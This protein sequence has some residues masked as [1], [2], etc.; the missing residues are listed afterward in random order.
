MIWFNGSWGIVFGFYFLENI[1]RA[2]ICV[3]AEERLG[4]Q[5]QF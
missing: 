3:D 1:W 4:I 5:G 2:N